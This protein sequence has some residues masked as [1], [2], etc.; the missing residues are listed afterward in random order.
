MPIGGF[1]TAPPPASGQSAVPLDYE[2][3]SVI[4]QTRVQPH[5]AVAPGDLFRCEKR[6]LKLIDAERDQTTKCRLIGSHRKAVSQG[7]D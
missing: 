1:A 7:H 6:C 4:D 2:V 5:E 3:S